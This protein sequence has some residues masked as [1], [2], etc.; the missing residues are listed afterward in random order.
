MTA[1]AVVLLGLLTVWEGPGE[2]VYVRHLREHALGAEA[3]AEQIATTL[4]T[5]AHTQGVPVELFVALAVLESGLDAEAE[6]RKGALGLLQLNPRSRWGRAWVA[7]CDA[8]QGLCG[9]RNAHWGA[10]ALRD[11][12]A[13]CGSEGAAVGFYRTGRCVTGP[14]ARQVL[15]LRARIRAAVSGRVLGGEHVRSGQSENREVWRWRG[16][17]N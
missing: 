17:Q 16:P 7:D 4:R 3:R 2:V 5:A 15:A 14:R 6:S 8:F 1:L 13:E 10:V 12:L 11:A 9:P